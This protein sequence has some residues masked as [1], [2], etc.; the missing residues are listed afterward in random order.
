MFS[1]VSRKD[2]N[3]QNVA[4][5]DILSLSFS[6]NLPLPLPYEMYGIPV[7]KMKKIKIKKRRR[8]STEHAHVIRK[9]THAISQCIN[10]SM[11]QLAAHT[12]RN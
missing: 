5:S 8:I 4:Y 9:H 11:N 6:V 7:K 10:T 3:F 12:Q 2:D 1:Y